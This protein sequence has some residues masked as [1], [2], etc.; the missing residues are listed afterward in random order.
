[1]DDLLPGLCALA[2]QWLGDVLLPRLVCCTNVT[3]SLDA[4]F[5][6]GRVKLH[7]QASCLVAGN[8]VACPVHPTS[9]AWISRR[10]YEAVSPPGWLQLHLAQPQRCHHHRR[11]H[12]LKSYFR[13]WT[14]VVQH[15]INPST[16]PESAR[17]DMRSKA[18]PGVQMLESGR[19]FRLDGLV[20]AAR[21]G[22]ASMVSTVSAS[23]R[24]AAGAAGGWVDGARAALDG[25]LSSVRAAY[26]DQRAAQSAAGAARKAPTGDAMRTD[27]RATSETQL[28]PTQRQQQSEEAAARHQARRAAQLAADDATAIGDTHRRATCCPCC[29][30]FPDDSWYTYIQGS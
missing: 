20:G 21:S 11:A 7:L 12:L 17:W 29:F 18:C 22:V 26:A 19:L 8:H 28:Q 9:G 13:G 16:L 10:L 30:A 23:A 27:G 15:H 2:Q 5:R 6:D 3:P 1:M 24:A 25:K 14:A 4:W